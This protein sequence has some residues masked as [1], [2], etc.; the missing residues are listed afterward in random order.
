MNSPLIILQARTGSTR[1]PNK[2]ILDFYEGKT[3]LE[4]ITENL[5]KNLIHHKSLLPLPKK[6]G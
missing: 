6:R 3:I 1:L 4:I 2:M 5:K